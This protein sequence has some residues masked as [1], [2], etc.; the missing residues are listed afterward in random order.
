M[1]KLTKLAR[2]L[3]YP[4]VLSTYT[5]YCILLGGG[6][7][8]HLE[9]RCEHGP[10]VCFAGKLN[11]IVCPTDLTGKHRQAAENIFC[12]PCLA[13]DRSMK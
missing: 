5:M 8:A 6:W 4:N 10:A 2:L 12:L 3:I 7:S 13:L 1:L 9:L 11:I